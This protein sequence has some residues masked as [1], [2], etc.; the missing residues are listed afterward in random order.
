MGR[1]YN[2]VQRFI[3][4]RKYGIPNKTHVYQGY[5]YDYYHIDRRD[6]TARGLWTVGKQG[7]IP[8]NT[9]ATKYVRIVNTGECLEVHSRIR[10]IQRVTIIAVPSVIPGHNA[11]V[12]YSLQ[13]PECKHSQYTL[14]SPDGRVGT[15]RCRWCL[16]LIYR[17][18][19]KPRHHR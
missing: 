14:Y 19:Y 6:I 15:F 9:C 5:V 8:V 18:T 17:R 4:G 13:C 12:R 2:H 11:G 1:H 10:L 7:R 3:L 16:K